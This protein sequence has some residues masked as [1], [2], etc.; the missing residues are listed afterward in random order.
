MDLSAANASLGYRV[1]VTENVAFHL[2]GRYFISSKKVF[3]NN[4]GKPS[5]KDALLAGGLTDSKGHS[6]A[7]P[8]ETQKG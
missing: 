6:D 8:I 4:I 5:T 1:A 3:F 2:E 7:C